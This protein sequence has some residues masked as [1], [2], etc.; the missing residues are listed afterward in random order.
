MKQIKIYGVAAGFVMC[1]LL[2]AAGCADTSKAPETKTG[3]REGIEAGIEP[4]ETAP[5][6]AEPKEQGPPVELALKFAPED[7][8]TYKVTIGAEKS[9]RWEGP[10]PSKPSAFKGGHTG[11][12]IE[13]TFTQQIQSTDDEGNAVA[14]ITIK[15]LKYL[16]KVKDNIILDFDSSREKD[17]NS[18]LSKLIGQSYTI[19]LTASGQVS[20][21]IEAS[22]ARAAV[23]GASTAH[24][25]A[26]KLL[27]EDVIKERHTIPAL[28]PADRGQLRT[29]DD[30]SSIKSFSFDLMGSKS[31]EKIY[32]LKEVKDTAGHR[33]AI[34][35]MNAIPSAEM[36]KEL[37][38]EQSTAF[39]S[40]MFDNTETYTGELRLDL[41]D[42]KVE[43]CREE[44]LTEWMIVDPSPKGDQPPAAL[45]M[46]ATRL[47]SIERA[48]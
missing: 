45:K 19:E 44:F 18:P 11:S 35:R 1:I 29:N 21:V 28:P 7:S 23:N 31:Y 38:K 48:D 24:K 26:V 13:T 12:T 16:Q 47:Y 36:A 41:T 30:W 20:Q 25:T 40:K 37:H 27:S 5:A 43:E 34:A 15:S 2:L 22:N 3:L 32:T 4:E 8:T 17:V 9:I 42:G 39:F 46:A 33:V 14:K 6:E 10:A